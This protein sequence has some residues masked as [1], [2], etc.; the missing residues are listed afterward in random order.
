MPVAAKRRRPANP[1]N[2]AKLSTMRATELRN[3]RIKSPDQIS[4]AGVSVGI[5]A[6]STASD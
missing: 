6:E 3:H 4:G 5:A 1:D 2:E